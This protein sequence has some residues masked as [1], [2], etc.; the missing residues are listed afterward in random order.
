VTR[1]VVVT[2]AAGA[3]GQAIARRLIQD[4][5]AVVGVDYDAERLTT[6]ADDAGITPIAGD[7]RKEQTLL[8]AADAAARQGSFGGWVNNAATFPRGRL[9]EMSAEEV[10]QA[11][12]GNLAPVVHGSRIALERFVVGGAGSIVTITSI[13]AQRASRAWPLYAVAKSGAEALMRAIAIDYGDQG[14]RANSVAPG[15]IRTDANAGFVEETRTRWE[16]QG[17]QL[18]VGAPEDVAAVVAFLLAPGAHHLNGACIA[19]DG[20]EAAASGAD[21]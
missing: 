15:L 16:G 14:I 4:D 12:Y 2:G 13:H 8:G 5:D 6:F 7:L 21:W 3:I 9:S 17:R 19:V 20:G 11:L 18:R 10:D 1:V